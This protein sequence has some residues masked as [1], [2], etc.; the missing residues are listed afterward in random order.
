[1]Q[2]LPATAVRMPRNL[3]RLPASSPSTTPRHAV[4]TGMLGCMHVAI[5]TPAM[6]MP[7]M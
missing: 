7:S 3:G 2:M 5:M 1:M 4:M 6:S